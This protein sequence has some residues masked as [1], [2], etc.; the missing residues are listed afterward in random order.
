MMSLQPVWEVAVGAVV[1]VVAMVIHGAG[2][3]LVLLRAAH[4]GRRGGAAARG[5][6]RQLFFG[7]LI[8]MMLGTHIFEMLVWAA[9]FTG[10][11]AIANVRDSF[12]LAAVTYTTLGYEDIKLPPEWRLLAPLC[13]MTGVFAFGWTTGVMVRILSRH[14]APTVAPG[15]LPPVRPGA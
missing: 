11:G 10:I 14:F 1:L 8:I 6:E 13:A 5:P 4:H 9:V 3:Y 2:M 7:A 15:S 12:Y